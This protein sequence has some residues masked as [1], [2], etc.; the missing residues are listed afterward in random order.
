MPDYEFIN[1]AVCP[2]ESSCQAQE[3]DG[4][5]RKRKDSEKLAL[6][7][8]PPAWGLGFPPFLSL[9]FSVHLCIYT[10]SFFHLRRGLRTSLE[11]EPGVGALMVRQ[12]MSQRWLLSAWDLFCLLPV[13]LLVS[14]LIFVFCFFFS[15]LSSSGF[16]V[17]HLQQPGS[18]ACLRPRAKETQIQRAQ[19]ALLTSHS[20]AVTL[21]IWSLNNLSH[22]VM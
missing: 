6:F 8:A 15:P 10:R 21:S 20:V 11:M 13:C 22:L 17:W 9:C 4:A 14:C 7:L 16:S 2:G 3:A 12:L 18:D 1:T 19:R 5:E